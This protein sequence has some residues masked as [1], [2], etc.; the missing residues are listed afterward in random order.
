MLS[1]EDNEAIVQVGPGTPMGELF[2]RYWTPALISEELPS[3]D[4]PPVRF[5]L[6]GE[7]LVGFRD[8]NGRIGIM[9]AYCPHRGAPLFFGRN[10]EC[11]LRCVYHG[12]KF[13][14][15][16]NCLELPNAPEGETFRHKVKAV[17]YPAWEGGG[18]IWAYMGP[19]EKQPPKPA[20]P[21]IDLPAEH[22]YLK[23]YY[24]HCSYL[25]A[26]E[27]DIDLTHLA[28]L[29]RTLDDN[30]RN[31]S[32]KLGRNPQLLDWRVPKTVRL[33]ERDYGLHWEYALSRGEGSETLVGQVHLIWPA[34]AT[35][36]IARRPI[37]PLQ[38]RVPIDD[39]QSFVYRL[40]WSEQPLPE[41]DLNEY[42]YGGFAYPPEEPGTFVARENRDNDYMID[43]IQQRFYSYTGISSVFA[44]D[45]AVVENQR[46]PIMDRTQE[47]LVSSDDVIIRLR[48]VLLRLA[49]DLAAGKEPPGPNN[50]EE[51]RELR[52]VSRVV[53]VGTDLERVFHPVPEA[54]PAPVA[55]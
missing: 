2:R 41:E 46:G 53:P 49:R 7:E 21:W 25:Q 27:G 22:R 15:D 42:R 4:C 28:F 31:P 35:I 30:A 45:L 34:M 47:H 23:K 43:R 54:Q 13:D 5:K 33:D 32:A 24:H 39:E 26:F 16:G 38:I 8:S 50:P 18:I 29:H 37:Q 52:S 20:F 9:D 12:W 48:R 36:G 40:R 3:P 1:R 19:A 10:E 51:L 11:G 55:V 6:L 17:A 14:V 44:Q